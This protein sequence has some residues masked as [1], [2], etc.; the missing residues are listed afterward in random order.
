MSQVNV[1]LVGYIFE[2]GGLALILWKRN[3]NF[4]GTGT[5]TTMTCEPTFPGMRPRIHQTL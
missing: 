1:N 4:A 3:E 2:F 5:P